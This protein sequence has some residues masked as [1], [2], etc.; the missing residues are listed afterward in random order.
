MW[1]ALKHL[2][3]K[4]WGSGKSHGDA[5]REK[6]PEGVEPLQGFGEDTSEK[7]D[8]L[9]NQIFVY[10]GL[11]GVILTIFVA[12]I[13]I[14]ASYVPTPSPYQSTAVQDFGSPATQRLDARLKAALETADR[15]AGAN[16]ETLQSCDVCLGVS[17]T[18]VYLG[19]E[20]ARLMKR[21]RRLEGRLFD[22]RKSGINRA[23]RDPAD[24]PGQVIRLEGQLASA[25]KAAG[26]AIS[27]LRFFTTA[28][29]D[30]IAQGLCQKGSTK[31]TTALTQINCEQDGPSLQAAAARL[32]AVGDSVSAEMATC[33][34]LTCVEMSCGKAAAL[35]ADLQVAGRALDVLMSSV[36]APKLHLSD[37]I[38]NAEQRAL[39]DAVALR[40]A[41][42]WRDLLPMVLRQVE[43]DATWRIVSGRL[44]VLSDQ[45]RVS[46][47]ERVSAQNEKSMPP[48]VPPEEG[49][50]GLREEMPHWRMSI[51]AMKLE[52]A[53][54]Q[55]E[56]MSVGKT[57]P[58]LF[59]AQ[60][61]GLELHLARLRKDLHPSQSSEPDQFDVV[62]EKR[63]GQAAGSSLA[64][65]LKRLAYARVVLEEARVRLKRCAVRAACSLPEVSGGEALRAVQAPVDAYE[66]LSQGLPLT[67]ARS[68][69]VIPQEA[70]ALAFSLS[71]DVY[72]AGEVIQIP[73][74]MVGNRC[75]WSSGQLALRGPDQRLRSYRLSGRPTSPVLFE[76]PTTPGDYMLV[77]TSAAEGGGNVLG[78]VPIRVEAMPSGCKGFT[79]QWQTEVGVLHLVERGA[80]VT[81]TYR[82]NDYA[83]A[84]FFIGKRRGRRVEGIWLSEIGAGKT[85]L[86]LA[87]NGRSF[88]GTW[89]AHL[90]TNRGGQ[91][92][93]RCMDT[94]SGH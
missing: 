25:R 77:A 44:A 74:T 81:G 1:R 75:L 33:Q 38:R 55:A 7:P 15:I 89:S 14:A 67:P 39:L 27:G 3:L 31:Q 9:L 21:I 51:L 47:S 53:A 73:E 12:L 61:A 93:G 72:R 69:E 58:E 56:L 48:P 45:L 68:L 17:D 91:W 6:R 71:E 46:A 23:D 10:S 42:E 36:A 64:C 50:E 26:L 29:D 86:I 59:V 88:S 85:K 35:D 79:G 37:K 92:N 60:L 2:I 30:C 13:M 22:E 8:A 87:K 82:Q 41:N 20:A 49:T 5:A 43:D 65:G 24:L 18:K 4:R 83:R 66:A 40:A 94:S 84:G 70:T 80:S 63:Q 16:T 34:E 76:A 11:A 62:E 19:N 54:V 52:Q 28:S 32:I 57:E 78:E 90:K